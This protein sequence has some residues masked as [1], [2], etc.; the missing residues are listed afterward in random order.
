MYGNTDFRVALEMLTP[1]AIG[2]EVAL[3]ERLVSPDFRRRTGT[4]RLFCKSRCG[5]GARLSS[6][7]ASEAS[8][9]KTRVSAAQSAKIAL[10]T[11]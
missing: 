7:V 1:K 10:T 9:D 8:G 5:C 11:P 2:F 3:R 6:S 4:I